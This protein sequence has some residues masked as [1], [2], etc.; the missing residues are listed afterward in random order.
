LIKTEDI[1][2]ACVGLGGISQGVL[3][4][5]LLY[6]QLN[7]FRFQS[8]IFA[9]GKKFRLAN[10]SRQY[11]R[12][13]GNKATVVK[14]NWLRFYPDI[15]GCFIECPEYITADNIADIIPDSSVVMLSVDN[16]QTR[17]LI[18][19]YCDSLANILLICGSNDDIDD[20][21]GQ[22][23]TRGLVMV[24]YKLNGE[25]QTPPITKHH[26]DIA[27]PQ[28]SH[29][30]DLSCE[31]LAISQPQI[32]ATNLAVGQAMVELLYRYMSLPNI[33][34]TEIVEIW[35]NAQ[36]QNR[37]FRGLKERPV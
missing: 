14:Q 21:N 24:H 34:A 26:D 35:L 37:A 8:I 17:K 16:H 29:P 7:I 10:E 22:D 15:G 27:K 3:P 1:S 13:T 33:Q 4:S 18:S 28:D 5:L 32:L 23:G 19:D 20:S 6:Q 11:F 2:C 25:N 9:D 36:T 12:E 30:T 31:E